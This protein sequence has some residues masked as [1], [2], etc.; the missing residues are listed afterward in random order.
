MH[1]FWTWW[2]VPGTVML[3]TAWAVA[4]LVYR[5]APTRPINQRLALVLLVGGGKVGF[6]TGLLFFFT[7]ARSAYTFAVAGTALHAA[8]PFLYLAFLGAALDTPLVRPF[9]SRRAFAFLGLLGLIAAAFVFGAPERFVSDLYHPDW[10]P[11]NFRRTGF[12]HIVNDV[13]AAVG[14]FAL[15]VAFI[16]LRRTI[17]GTAAR[18]RA[19]WFLIAFGIRD[20][21][22]A[23]FDSMYR[24]IRPIE[25]WGE[26]LYNP[27]Q[28][29]FYLVFVLCL[30][31]GVL[32]TQLLD[33]HIKLRFAIK[34]STVGA[35]IAAVFLVISEGIES[36]APASGLIQT[37]IAAAV[38]VVA[39]RPLQ[40]FADRLAGR[41]VGGAGDSPGYFDARRLEVYRAAVE[42]AMEDGEL[43]A[44]EAVI[45]A[46]LR[47]KLGLTEAEAADIAG[48]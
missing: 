31:Y 2:A 45:L 9:R 20:V 43:T 36:V 41:L 19:K 32:S 25:F 7:S 11:W 10:A 39:L 33:I 15:I 28:A 42:G 29:L 24:V 27:G 26:F 30:A 38:I 8:L 13:D 12:G 44:K 6:T 35:A 23:V 40:R 1:F 37:I 5:T 4:A 14:I 48:K 22:A 3:L 18:Q 16:A 17:H 47:E 46:R 34:Q 21:Y